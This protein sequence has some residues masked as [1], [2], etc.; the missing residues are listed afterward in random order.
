MAYFINGYVRHSRKENILYT[1][2][3]VLINNILF[4]YRI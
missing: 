4:S 3:Y 2:K 1:K